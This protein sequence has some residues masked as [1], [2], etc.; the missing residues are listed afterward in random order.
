MATYTCNENIHQEN[1]HKLLESSKISVDNKQFLKTLQ[2]HMKKS[3]SHTLTFQTQERIGKKPT[4][5]LY[6]KFKHPSLQNCPRLLRGCLAPEYIEVDIVNCFPTVFLQLFEQNGIAVP[7]TL[8]AYV[9]DR[10]AFVASTG[11]EKK[12]VKD[13]MNS[14]MNFG[15]SLIPAFD[16]FGQQFRESFKA[17]CVVPFYKKYYDLGKTRAESPHPDEPYKKAVHFV[18]SDVERQIVMSA[19][20]TF[21]DAGFETSTV[22]HDGFLVRTADDYDT[23]K[24]NTSE[25]LAKCTSDA[26]TKTGYQLKFDVKELPFE[27]EQ[28]FD[29]NC[30]PMVDED[31]TDHGASV[32]F[33]SFMNDAGF[34]FK[35]S[36][37]QVYMYD[38]NSH[39]WSDK[40]DGW[41]AQCARCEELGDYGKSTPRQNQLWVQFED[42]LMD[43]EQL[44]FEFTEQNY[45]KIA[46]LN[47]Y[48]DFQTKEFTYWE[49]AENV[50]QCGFF[51]KVK[52]DWEE[53]NEELI[54]EIWTKCILEVY[55]EE[56]G[57]FLLAVLGRAAAGYVEDKMLYII[58]GNTN[59]GKGVMVN[60]LE[61]AFGKG[62]VG[63][64]NTGVLQHKSVPDEAKGLSFMVALKDKRFLIGSE[65]SRSAVFDS[66]KINMLCS[67]GDTICARQNN[68]DEMEFRMQG[69]TFIFCNDMSKVNGLDDSVAN[70]L[71]F[72]EPKYSFLA[73]SE[74]VRKQL[75]PNVKKADDSIKTHFVKR[76]DV[77]HAFAMMVCLAFKDERPKEPAQVVQQNSDWLN[78]EDVEE[79][80]GRL[81]VRKT[82]GVVC[83]EDLYNKCSGVESL[84]NMSQNKITRTLAVAFGV[85]VPVMRHI[86]GRGS[87]RSYINIELIQDDRDW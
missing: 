5:R 59:S 24:N 26:Q 9:S 28:L 22:I 31:M 51:E 14:A 71:R 36:N 20:Q 64:F 44:M 68:K 2:K 39:V 6:T 40:V 42:S 34:R 45:M 15:S 32:I 18:G 43:E 85:T 86:A 60:L 12:A 83:C 56:Q 19:I 84:K 35:K 57:K 54:D 79:A 69:T 37:G 66:Q 17:L 67:G 73:G 16:T 53:P 61:K 75:Q 49:Q 23:F 46:F 27:P 77:G 33:A 3:A 78:A 80:L 25:L 52:Y 70:R 63:T 38:P 41:R 11:H 76:D 48:Y 62:Y 8:T 47:G 29:D 58:L 74:Y 4:G 21:Q 55:G 82:G 30:A 87:K 1:L 10:E 13:A 7:A 65:A 81:V 50:D 72:I